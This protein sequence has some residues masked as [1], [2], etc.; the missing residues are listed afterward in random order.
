MNPQ[1]EVW[2]YPSPQQMLNAMT[3]KGYET[4]NPEDVPA[5]VAVHNFINEGSW[6]QILQWEKKYFLYIPPP[7]TERVK[8]VDHDRENEHP[9]LVKFSGRPQKPTPK[10]YLLYMTGRCPKAFDHHEWFI[11]TPEQGKLRRYVIDYYGVDELTFSVDA[12]PAMDDFPSLKARTM[13]FM[14]DMKAKVAGNTKDGE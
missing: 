12:R 13:K 10:S 2:E 4:Q 11:S 6:E 1:G 5:M 7:P 9:H 3:R 14:D 8:R